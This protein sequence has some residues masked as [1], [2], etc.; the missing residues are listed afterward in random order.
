MLF[1][2]IKSCSCKLKIH[3]FITNIIHIRSTELKP[4]FGFT[5]AG[6]MM[7]SVLVV[8]AFSA[9]DTLGFSSSEK[10]ISKEVYSALIL[11]N[12][13]MCMDFDDPQFCV[14]NIAYMKKDPGMCN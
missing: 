7:L 3:H 6:I 12:A 4:F 13:E 10:S 2:Y 5:I 9:I 11:D 1:L 14:S 8:F